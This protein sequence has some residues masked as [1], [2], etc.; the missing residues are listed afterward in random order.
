MKEK[1]NLQKTFKTVEEGHFFVLADYWED[2][3][4]M[5]RAAAYKVVLV[6]SKT[7]TIEGESQWWKD[8]LVSVILFSIAGVLLI[9][10]IVLLFI[11]PSDEKLEDLDK[12]V[13]K[14][15]KEK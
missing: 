15:R 7:A 5:Q 12:K 10:V 4:P 9:L 2:A 6:E 3:D 8:N 14:K 1:K 13:D 11:K